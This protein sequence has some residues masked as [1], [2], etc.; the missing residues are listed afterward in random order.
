MNTQAVDQDAPPVLINFAFPVVIVNPPDLSAPVAVVVPATH[1]SADSSQIQ[2]A[3]FPVEP[4][5]TIIPASFVLADIPLFNSKMLSAITVL[6]V[7]TVVV[8]PL[9]V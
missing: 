7:E 5:S 1:S 6:V 3:L 2:Q 8:V 4:L 9:T